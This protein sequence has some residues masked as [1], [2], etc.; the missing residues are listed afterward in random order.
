MEQAAAA[1]PAAIAIQLQQHDAAHEAVKI[2]LLQVEESAEKLKQA[3]RAITFVL[4][5]S[6]DTP[7]ASLFPGVTFASAWGDIEPMR[8]CHGPC[9]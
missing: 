1:Q 4:G 9:C 6:E 7:I 5:V 2:T 3:R 8:Q